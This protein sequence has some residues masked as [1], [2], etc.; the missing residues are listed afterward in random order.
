MGYLRKVIQS[1]WLMMLFCISS[2]SVSETIRVTSND[3]LAQIMWDASEGDI[4]ELEE[5]VYNAQATLYSPS[6]PVFHI[7][8]PIELKAVGRVEN[9]ILQV[10]SDKDQVIKVHPA[11]YQNTSGQ[12]FITN[13]S[14]ALIKGI[15]LRGSM[16]G[17]LVRDYQNLTGGKLSNV[18]L[19]N[20]VI[21]LQSP[22]AGHGIELNN[23]NNA[24]VDG[25]TVN[26]AYANGIY[27][28][29]SESNIISHNTIKSSL[30]QHAIGIKG[31]QK[32][33]IIENTIEGAAADGIILLYSKENNVARNRI[34]GFKV[35]GITLTDGSQF[36][37][38][39]YNKILSTG[40]VDGR[41]DGTGI[42]L[43][44][45][46]NHNMVIGNQT[47]GSPENG[48]TIFSA[49]GNLITKNQASDN[50]DGGAFIWENRNF[51]FN[52][53]YPGEVPTNNTM[54]HN[55]F[56]NNV[57]NAMIIVR[58]GNE[59]E[60]GFNFLSGLDHFAG[61]LAGDNTGGIQLQSADN[62]AIF[63]NTISD[64][65]NAHYI[66]SDVS[67]TQI[68]N[69]RHFN[70][71]LNYA[72]SPATVDWSMDNAIGGNYWD[73]FAV[74]GNPSVGQAYTD[75]VIDDIGHR[76]GTNSDDFPFASETLGKSYALSI[77]APNAGQAIVNSTSRSIEWSS[78]GCM[79]IDITMM[80]N[81]GVETRIES[82]YPDMGFYL[83]D[84]S[85]VATG[86]YSIFL[87]CKNSS[88]Q[89]T[90]TVD[91]VSNVTISDATQLKLITPSAGD[92]Y[93]EGSTLTVA[94]TKANTVS[95]V[96]VY[97]SVD[98]YDEVLLAS[99]V[100][101]TQV[102]IALPS[103]LTGS[104]SIK[105]ESAD[106]V[107]ADSVSSHFSIQNNISSVQTA[108][109]NVQIN[110]GETVDITWLSPFGTQWVS[111][112][113]WDGSMWS[114]IIKRYSDSG[115]YSWIAK[116]IS[117]NTTIRI[118]FFNAN[119][120]QLAATE[121]ALLNIEQSACPTMLSAEYQLNISA[122]NIG[123]GIYNLVLNFDSENTTTASW[124][125][126]SYS[127]ITAPSCQ[128]AL[129]ENNE[130]YIPEI[131]VGGQVYWVRLGVE[132][133]SEGVKASLSRFDTLQ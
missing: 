67:N 78:Q 83:W 102:D 115:E 109:N 91:T 107:W 72:L 95:T 77:S 29:E 22:T 108:S 16:G 90:G 25:N 14:G 18:Q 51:C 86:N 88:G 19:I 1:V 110:S 23:V 12:L 96:N 37:R 64:V 39:A 2:V 36:N 9:T 120:V 26:T 38:V 54:T 74:N 35:D 123:G 128:T 98:E 75:F 76:G 117:D 65:N 116:N 27:L 94:W 48:I 4:I 46:S 112:D 133:D 53:T 125:V 124:R 41:E 11:S 6:D 13:P 69:N 100:T 31:G 24:F 66:F 82:N 127:T 8:R 121:K 71:A 92:E 57:S 32:N 56:N 21:D 89:L 49:S 58:G 132:I 105:I 61:T 73:S 70:F 44:C 42:W 52:A 85:S 10:P 34:S 3:N 15:T 17:L 130:I 93:L 129:F 101:G 103:N 111:I 30:T 59:T 47:S 40:R 118:Q 50:F 131:T 84:A 33:E 28:F 5:G 43:N 60:L 122:I 79:Y 106:H 63:G 87:M 114:S 99:T 126:G 119:G 97:L 104:A 80:D 113:V 55:I 81:A 45:N 62:I 7:I 20:T 68:Y